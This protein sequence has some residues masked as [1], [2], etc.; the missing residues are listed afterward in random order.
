MQLLSKEALEAW[1]ATLPDD[2]LTCIETIDDS[3]Q[4]AA[5]FISKFLPDLKNS[6]DFSGLVSANREKFMEMGRARRIRF[7]AWCAAKFHSDKDE[8]LRLISKITETGSSEE[9]SGSGNQ[10]V[11]IL[12]LEDIK[13]FAAAMGPRAA[14]LIVDENT[15]ST[16]AGVGLE[17]ASDMELRGGR[18]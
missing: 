17:M 15:L 4:E 18:K 11:G 9:G 14:A 10:S 2:V 6:D 16:V 1:R 5:D 8:R 3:G 7:L 12:F 13:A